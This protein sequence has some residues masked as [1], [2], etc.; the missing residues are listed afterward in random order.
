MCRTAVV[1]LALIVMLS[2]CPAAEAVAQEQTRDL[3]QMSLEDLLDIKVY[4]ASK[5]PQKISEAPASISIVT[6]DQIARYGHRTLAEVLRTIAG[7]QFTNDRNYSYLGLRGFSRPGDYNSRILLLIDGHRLNDNI[8]ESILAGYESPIDLDL[9]DRIE[10]I[11]GPSSSLYG[12]S[13]FFGVINVV[14]KT[15]GTWNGMNAAVEAGSFDTYRARAGYGRQLANGIEF[16]VSGSILD[17]AGKSRLF[18]PAFDSPDTNNGFAENADRESNRTFYASFSYQNWSVRAGYGSRKKIIPTGAYET[19]FNSNRS[20]SV[21]SRSFVDIKYEKVFKNQLQL[22]ARTSFDRY[23][24]YG[25][26][27]YGSSDP[28]DPW[29]VVNRD[30]TVGDWWTAEL[31]LSK[32]LGSRNHLTG[33][34]EYRDNFQQLQEN[35]DV[36]P[37]YSYLHSDQSSNVWAVYLQDELTIFKDLIFSAGVRHDHYESFG[38]TTNPRLGLIYGA[39]KSTTF[40]VLY[41][42][43]FRAPNAFELFYEEPGFYRANPDLRPE[44]IRTTEVVIER[45]L[46]KKVRFSGAGYYYRLRNLI[47]QQT[48]PVDDALIYQNAEKINAKGIELQLAARDLH[49]VQGQ[50]SYSVQQAL[51]AATGS[52]LSNSPRHMAKAAVIAPFLR[53]KAFAGVEAFYMGK[54]KTVSGD[55]AGGFLLSNLTL[56]SPKLI[57]GFDL[58]AS[59]YNLFNKHYG[60]PVSEE[61]P[62]SAIEQDGRTF[63]VKLTYMLTQ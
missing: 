12:T 24:Y 26:Y 61:V 30:N 59:I 46:G 53:G 31:Q 39:S 20:Y 42:Q 22:T 45:A 16:L 29:L 44:T 7:F 9:V 51:D 5:F 35:Y 18:F 28:E 27:L 15:G 21:D 41:G 32:K 47:S 13:A 6:A 14:T 40:K 4:S 8:Y 49:G 1:G 25:D 48:D 17:S 52:F 33:G 34:S 19:V 63:R 37:Y 36:D 55:P 54:R 50:L 11:R 60:D 58:S 38:G 23:L 43:A 56:S 10:V 57:P 3:T 62:Q 2:F